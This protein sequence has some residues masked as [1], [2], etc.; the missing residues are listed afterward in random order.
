MKAI[1]AIA[2]A[3]V[4]LVGCGEGSNNESYTGVPKNSSSCE[5]AYKVQAN[6]VKCTQED[7][8]H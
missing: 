5:S 7:S 1:L 6:V 4:L 8:R 2:L 3:S